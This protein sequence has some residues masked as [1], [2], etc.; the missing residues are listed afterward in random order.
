M[1]LS[2][3]LSSHYSQLLGLVK[4]WHITNIDLNVVEQRVDVFIEWPAGKPV[5]CPECNKICSTKDLREERI[6]RHLDTMQ[7][8]TYLHCRVPRSNCP[9]HGIKTITVPWGEANTRWTLLFEAFALAVMEQVPSISRAA[10]LLHM[11]WDQVHAIRKHAVQ[12][13]MKRRT[14]EKVSYLGI[15]EKSFRSGS[16][17]ITI[18]NDLEGER[19]LEVAETK[20]KEAA[21]AV[22][23]AI[24]EQAR[25]GVR[26]VA[27]DMTAAYETVT[28]EMFPKAEVVYDKFHVE[29]ML[30]KAV[31]H[32]RRK[33]HKS[34]LAQGI[35]IFRHTRY[36]W[37]KRPERWTEKQEQQFRDVEAAFTAGKFAQTKV[38]RVWNI[39]EMF[40]RF[41]NYWY[42]AN[43][44]HYFQR[45]YFWATHSRMKPVIAVAK[46]L[47]AHLHGLLAYFRHRITNSVSEGMNA[48]I[49]QL[50]A[51]ARGFRSF[52]NYRIAILFSCGKLNMY[53]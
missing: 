34:L 29:Q 31:D 21:R 9:S 41:W 27:M 44:G 42:P 16:S 51:G 40:R 7:F 45:W 23:S 28:R 37:L 47:N 10:H 33:E 1:S 2:P 49:Q 3:V 26:A 38:G 15:D 25:G 39:K 43:A 48:K 4:P 18:L 30:N 6:W 12:R 46:T 52:A 32:V 20:S 24:P 53:P 35:D 11:S 5:R 36:V 17:C 8:Q 13:G 50:K 22:Y 19:V 14:V